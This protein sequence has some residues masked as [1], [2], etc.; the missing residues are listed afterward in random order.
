M[1]KQ[2]NLVES[3]FIEQVNE[4]GGFSRKYTSPGRRGVP[5]RIAFLPSL[6]AVFVELKTEKGNLSILQVREIERMTQTGAACAVLNSRIEIDVFF[7]KYRESLAYYART[8]SD[9]LQGMG[10]GEIQSPIMRRG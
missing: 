5:D 7:I 4:H 8:Q 2:E 6:G 9:E 10:P 3:Y 1:G